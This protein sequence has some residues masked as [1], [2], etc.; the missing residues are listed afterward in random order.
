MQK[1]QRRNPPRLS[2]RKNRTILKIRN[3][4]KIKS[5]KQPYAIIYQN[6]I[7][8][9]SLYRFQVYRTFQHIV[10]SALSS[11]SRGQSLSFARDSLMSSAACLPKTK[12]EDGDFTVDYNYV[13]AKSLATVAY[14][15]LKE[16]TVC[17]KPKPPAVSLKQDGCFRERRY[18]SI[19]LPRRVR[20]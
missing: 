8:I 5:G 7:I 17:R 15:I 18:G 11:S 16:V 13:E 20:R 9:F 19:R 1:R 10:K 6:K 12:A 2:P 4:I 14:L 3:L